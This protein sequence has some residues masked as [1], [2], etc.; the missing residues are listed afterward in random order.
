[1]AGERE[2][3]ASSVLRA[4]KDQ[5]ST[6]LGEET[7]LLSLRNSAYYGLD[8]VGTS[9]WA[10]LAEPVSVAAIRDALVQEY[11]APAQ[12]CEADLI[13]LL[14]DLLDHGLIEIVDETSA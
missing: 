7:V 13:V 14:K 2:I 12:T 8:E 6:R 3:D 4:V 9:I 1:M 11:D 10:L 5:V